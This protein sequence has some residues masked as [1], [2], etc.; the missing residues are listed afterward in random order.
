MVI[1]KNLPTRMLKMPS[2]Y[3][4]TADVPTRSILEFLRWIN[5]PHNPK[6][7]DAQYEWTHDA[8]KRGIWG[9]WYLGGPHCVQRVMPKDLPEK[10]VLSKMRNL[11]K[12]G[13]VDGCPCGCRGDYEI[14][15]KGKN[16]L[17][18]VKDA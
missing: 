6:Y 16:Y 17:D 1:Q 3:I 13:L 7:C 2:T 9:N 11:I 5:K 14:T 10:L 8:C 15:D 4:K 12:R 18:G